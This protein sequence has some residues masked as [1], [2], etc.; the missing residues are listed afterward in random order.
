MHGSEAKQ[1]TVFV[2]DGVSTGTS[3]LRHETEKRFCIFND[4]FVQ[5]S[6]SVKFFYVSVRACKDEMCQL[7]RTHSCNGANQ[8]FFSHM[9]VRACEN[10]MCQLT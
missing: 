8:F 5:W 9:S 6:K 7:S 1:A 3:T 4:L 10:A 2:T